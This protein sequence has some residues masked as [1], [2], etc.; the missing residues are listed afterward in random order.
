MRALDDT[1]SSFADAALEL[2]AND[3]MADVKE[4]A[5][6]LGNVYR[7]A[8]DARLRIAARMQMYLSALLTEMDAAYLADVKPLKKAYAARR[9]EARD[10][11]RAAG[12]TAAAAPSSPEPW[13]PLSA[14]LRHAAAAF[15]AT[16]APRV[17]AALHDF[18]AHEAASFSEVCA[19]AATQPH[20]AAAL[21]RRMRLRCVRAAA[22]YCR[23]AM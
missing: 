9:A 7:R 6:A 14:Q 5:I 10:K 18:A 13:R 22:Q 2:H 17:V 16:F 4:A 12:E 11:A 15:V 8:G 21:R 19:H 3:P 20:P 1:N 23:A